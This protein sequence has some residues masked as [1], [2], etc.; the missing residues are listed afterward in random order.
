M[1]GSMATAAS[2]VFDLPERRELSLL[3]AFADLTRFSAQSLRVTDEVLA[4]TVDAHYQRVAARVERAD[5]KVVKFIGDAA[6]VVFA[7][8][9][10]DAGVGALLDLKQE[11][12]AWFESLGWE[13]RMSIKVH[14]GAAIAG[15]FGTAATFDVIGKAVNTTAMLD[16]TGVALSADAFRKLS[17]DLRKRFKK[18]TPT[19]T[20]IRTEDP[21]RFRNR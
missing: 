10:V 17:P 4:D 2:S 1:E 12:D 14:F 11:V 7:P 6:L 5:G 20:Y 19:I 8:D 16:S 18:H 13:C 21:H 3:I 15:P 9:A